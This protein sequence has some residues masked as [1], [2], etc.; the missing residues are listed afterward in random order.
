[1]QSIKEVFYV[2]YGPSSSHTI[3]PYNAVK[4]ILN[5]YNNIKDIKVTLFGSLAST[6]KGHLTDYIIDK[7]LKDIP[8]TI[9]FNSRKRVKHPNTM[10]FELTLEDNTKKKETIIS[11]GGGVIKV[12]GQKKNKKKNYT[13]IKHYLKY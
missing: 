5:K 11:I 8:H 2:G 7:F 3:G 12:L 6:G 10:L 9:S 1:M 13:L 4:Y